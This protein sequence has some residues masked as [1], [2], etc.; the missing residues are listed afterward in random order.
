LGVARGETFVRT[1]ATKENMN[2]KANDFYFKPD[3]WVEM[4][5]FQK[6]SSS[7]PGKDLI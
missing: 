7:L 4:K 1:Q 3:D 2:A 5:N 6:R